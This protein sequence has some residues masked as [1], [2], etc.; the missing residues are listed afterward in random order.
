MIQSIVLDHDLSMHSAFNR[1]DAQRLIGK[2][3]T[4]AFV[5]NLSLIQEEPLAFVRRLR[6]EHPE[7]PL[8]ALVDSSHQA[9]TVG[10]LQS[11]TY[12]CLPLPLQVGDLAYNLTKILASIADA[13]NPFSMRY[14][15]RILIMPND[16]SLVM[17]VA[18]NLVETTLPL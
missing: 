15:E 14:E 8:I 12:A 17:Q 4:L 11:G 7:I 10:L 9:L 5:C 2:G 1:E 6:Q 18:K 16:F 3:R 13:Y